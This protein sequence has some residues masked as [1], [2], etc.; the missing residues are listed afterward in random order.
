MSAALLVVH[1][2]HRML[3]RI[4]DTG[5]DDEGGRGDLLIAEP[6]AANEW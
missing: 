6:A 5:W 4:G 1:S 2:T 3:D